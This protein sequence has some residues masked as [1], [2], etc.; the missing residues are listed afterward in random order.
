MAMENSTCKFCLNE[1]PNGAWK[2]SH[3]G[4]SQRWPT[5]FPTVQTTLVLLV[6]LVSVVSMAI[7]IIHNAL[8]P[9]DSDVTFN[10]IDRTDI[11]IPIIASNKGTRPASI[12]SLAAFI[13]ESGEPGS[14]ERKKH[15]LFAR[16]VHKDRDDLF[17][18]ENTSRQ[19]IYF[20]RTKQLEPIKDVFSDL[21]KELKSLDW[22]RK[23][24]V[25]LQYINF[26]GYR[27]NQEIVIYDAAKS[28]SFADSEDTTAFRLLEASGCF[29]KI[30]EPIRK[31]FGILTEKIEGPA[32]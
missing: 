22:I 27:Q 31:K 5:F 15:F 6:A 20:V 19:L 16:L 28:K 32:K 2:C 9:D 11:S 30:P 1:I 24:T 4:S 12:G 18:P 8:S 7:P 17:L 23:C 25:F 10:Y 14:S 29:L 3:C 26:S 21:A 13:V